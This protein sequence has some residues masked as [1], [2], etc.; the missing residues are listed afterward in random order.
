MVDDLLALVG[1]FG[2]LPPAGPALAPASS[3][4]PA[5]LTAVWAGLTGQVAIDLKS[6]VYGRNAEITGLTGRLA[7]EPA[8]VVVDK[9]AGKVGPDGQLQ[10]T[11]EVRF[12]AGAPQPY[13]SKLDF[14]LQGFEVGPL[15][16]IIA[17]NR[18]PTIEG[19]FDIRSHAEG[20]GRTLVDL[21]GR[22]RGD[23]T[24]QSRKGVFRGLQQATVSR[25]AGIISSAA[26]LLGTLGEKVENLA[27]RADVTAE[28]GGMFAQLPY[29]QLNLRLSRDQ[30][31]NVKLS[32]FSLVSPNVRLQGDGQI[33]Y[34]A[35]K[36]LLNQTM[37][38]RVNMGV[39]GQVENVLARAK[40][41]LLSSQIV[42]TIIKRIKKSI[43]YLRDQEEQSNSK[44]LA[45]QGIASHI[46][47]F[48]FT[49]HFSTGNMSIGSFKSSEYAK[50]AR[51]NIEDY[52]H[53]K[54]DNLNIFKKL[55]IG[56]D[57][58]YLALIISKADE[59]RKSSYLLD[60]CIE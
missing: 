50:Q 44:S 53:G 24:L 11:A 55:A 27:T 41:S 60:L 45:Q 34:E 39:M 42:D 48:S 8:R 51:Y 9:V 29:D 59:D 4:P 43:Q 1:S 7:I 58:E 14:N 56:F 10:L 17:P 21:I 16:K 30:S 20:T 32:D 6:L 49:Y 19:R 52:I 25:A 15:F 47:G 22:T 54:T 23:L 35:G 5:D 18:P 28:L 38:V 31:L 57:P 40:S 46:K 36:S 13:T 37:Q 33:T 12:A 2:P 26:R 3:N